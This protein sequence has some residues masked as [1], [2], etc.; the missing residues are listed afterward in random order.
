MSNLGN[1]AKAFADAN[2]LSLVSMRALEEQF[3]RNAS[4]VS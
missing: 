2:E 1:A 3:G 4:A